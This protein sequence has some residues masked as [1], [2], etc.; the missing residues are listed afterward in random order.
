MGKNRGAVGGLSRFLQA[1]KETDTPD[2]NTTTAST[3]TVTA[4]ASSTLVRNQDDTMDKTESGRPNKKR[5]VGL[6]G[7]GYERNDATTL[8]QFYTDPSEVPDHLKKC[9]C[10]H[11]HAQPLSH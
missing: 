4:I 2:S 8:V 7:I 9:T 3:T 6:L 11:L 5:K 1:F 10:I